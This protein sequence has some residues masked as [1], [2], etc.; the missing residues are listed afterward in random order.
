M[1]DWRAQGCNAPRDVFS[2]RAR[3]LT[4]QGGRVA[5]RDVAERIRS[6][7]EWVTASGRYL[8]ATLVDIGLVS[9]RALTQPT[10]FSRRNVFDHRAALAKAFIFYT[11]VFALV[12]S[13]WVLASGFQMF[14]G[15]SQPRELGHKIVEIAFGSIVIYICVALLD[16]RIKF[17]ELLQIILYVDALYLLTF[18]TVK[19]P[20]VYF[21]YLLH[22]PAGDREVDIF[23][24]EVERCLSKQSWIYWAIR[25][26]LKYFLFNDRWKPND[27][28]NFIFTHSQYLFVV[29]FL[30]I[31]AR[32][33]RAHSRRLMTVALV[34]ISGLAFVIAVEGSGV[35]VRTINAAIAA[36]SD[37]YKQLLSDVTN[38][39]PAAVIARNL[40][41]K[42]ANELKKGIVKSN[43]IIT[44][45]LA[46]DTF[47]VDAKIPRGA[48]LNV[49]GL[50]TA[51]RSTYC[52][53]QFHWIAVRAIKYDL[54]VDVRNAE[55]GLIHRIN[56][57]D[58]MYLVPG[59]YAGS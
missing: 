26:E 20:I 10:E 59:G 7:I 21:D 57:D 42:L 49:A 1:G 23:A 56:L 19:I 46:G 15:L 18:A 24:T 45:R 33:V 30:F 5:L 34:G 53:D 11:K 31:F 39:Y 14:D 6:P 27:W 9:W 35:V 28:Y 41:Y 4:A 32:M 54:S 52:S 43:V 48:T 50:N 25:G 12:F 3:R 13:F 8:T 37:C 29:P 58:R 47:L 51:M 38:K 40:E 55:G 22:V 44:F 17:L 2:C 36:N 16:R